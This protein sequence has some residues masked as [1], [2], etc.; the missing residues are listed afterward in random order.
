MSVF[1]IKVADGKDFNKI[2]NLIKNELG[3]SNLNENEAI[4]RLDFFKKS[5]AYE[6]F[7]AVENEQVIGFI[8][9]MKSVAYNINGY[10]SQILA[11]AVTANKRHIG[12]GTALVKTVEDWSLS[13]G[14]N[15]ISVNSGLKRL[16]AHSF[17][18]KN[19]YSKKRF[20]F[21]KMI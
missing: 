14:I 12:V 2:Y 15:F 6:T 16:D 20:S 7:V 18:E 13:N 8:G 3:Y 5:D 21:I 17:Y 19:G 4:K 1:N 9:V 11:L 10:Y